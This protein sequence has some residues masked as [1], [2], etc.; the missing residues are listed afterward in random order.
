[1]FEN[2]FRIYVTHELAFLH[3]P[4]VRFACQTEVQIRQLKLSTSQKQKTVESGGKHDLINFLD[5]DRYE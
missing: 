4:S 2:S 1:M 5:K 3:M